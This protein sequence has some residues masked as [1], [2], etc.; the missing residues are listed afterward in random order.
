VVVLHRSV[1]NFTPLDFKTPFFLARD[2]MDTD[3][4]DF[5]TTNVSPV[6]FLTRKSIHEMSYGLLFIMEC[7]YQPD[8]VNI[9][10][11]DDMVLT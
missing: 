2:F 1:P 10:D 5:K 3:T 8:Q 4:K 11:K 9:A 6:I 7:P